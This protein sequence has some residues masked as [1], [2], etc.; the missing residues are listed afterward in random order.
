MGKSTDGHSRASHIQP[1]FDAREAESLHRK[2]SDQPDAEAGCKGACKAPC[3]LQC[4][5]GCEIVYK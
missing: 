2:C 4:K 5:S 1:L 3:E